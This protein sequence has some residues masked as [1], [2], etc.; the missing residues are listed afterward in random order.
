MAFVTLE[1]RRNASTADKRGG[2]PAA[3][4]LACRKKKDGSAGLP[5]CFISFTKD[6]GETAGLKAGEKYELL[7][8]TEK[9]KGFIRLRKDPGGAVKPRT[10][11]HGAFSFPC[12]HVEKFGTEAEPRTYCDAT[13]IEKG[14][15]EIKLPAWGDEIED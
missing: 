15:V 8:G 1:I 14:V 2:K 4:K 13:V 11:M 3:I 10:N 12:G 6:F 9:H 5:T 7:L